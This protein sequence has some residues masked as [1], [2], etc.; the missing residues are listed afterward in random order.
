MFSLNELNML[1]D[2]INENTFNM[3]IEYI[4][5]QRSASFVIFKQMEKSLGFNF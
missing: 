3:H 4:T 2:S 1:L 5:C